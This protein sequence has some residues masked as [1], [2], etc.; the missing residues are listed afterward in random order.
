[1]KAD[2][3]LGKGQE[4]CQTG[5]TG[6]RIKVGVGCLRGVFTSKSMRS[7]LFTSQGCLGD[8]PSLFPVLFVFLHK[9]W[10]LER[11]RERERER[12]RERERELENFIL[13]GL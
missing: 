8:S 9:S 12:V 4:V 1:M 13:Q 5:H 3:T 11:E 7:V 2:D 10:V 6:W